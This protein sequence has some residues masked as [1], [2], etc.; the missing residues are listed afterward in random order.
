MR[1]SERSIRA[2]MS[3]WENAFF[4][5]RL[6]LRMRAMVSDVMLAVVGLHRRSL[7]YFLIDCLMRVADY[8]WQSMVLKSRPCLGAEVALGG[9]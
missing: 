2:S 4:D 6:V 8:Y 7:V 3:Y 1:T 9:Q 5:L